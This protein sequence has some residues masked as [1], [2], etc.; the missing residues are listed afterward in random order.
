MHSFFI[1]IMKTDHIARMVRLI[2]Y[3]QGQHGRRHSFSRCSEYINS[4]RYEYQLKKGQVVSLMQ[5]HRLTNQSD[6]TVILYIE[7]SFVL[8]MSLFQ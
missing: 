7:L 6:C 4:R 1:G 8:H 3:L 2:E 5:T